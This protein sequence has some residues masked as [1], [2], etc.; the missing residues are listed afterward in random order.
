MLSFGL[1]LLEWIQKHRHTKL[2]RQDCKWQV[3]DRMK[4]YGL[5]E[6]GIVQ[7]P[8]GKTW[9]G[10]KGELW[11]V[12][13][14]RQKIASYQDLR[15]MLATGSNSADVI[16]ELVWVGEGTE[17]D[18]EGL[19]VTGK[20]VVSSASAGRVHNIACVQKGAFGIISF[21]SPR[22][23]VDPLSIP[24]SGLRS[25]GEAQAKFAFYLP[26]RDGHIL[27]DRLKRGEKI[28]V[29]AQVESKMLD[30]TL[31]DPVCVILGTDPNADEIIFS[32][33]LFEGYAKQGAN[34]NISGSAVIL[35]IAR[36]LQKLI[37]EGRIP[38]PKRNIRFFVGA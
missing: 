26:P 35:E 19:D 30:Y 11:E 6:A 27:R 7:F 12:S 22:P 8:G 31:Q 10:I 29:H 9:D 1:K 36:T 5:A 25:R 15:A 32:A 13:P 20:I 16:A 17:K 3:L 38:R 37:N 21:N 18:F 23:L 4:E 34:D 24:F 14:Q 28:T 2:P 33:H